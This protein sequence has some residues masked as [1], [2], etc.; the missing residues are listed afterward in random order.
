METR[1]LISIQILCKR[2]SIPVSFVN[3]LHDYNLIELTVENNDFFIHIE[4]IKDVEKMM[5]LYY[6]LGIN[7][8][9]MDVIYNLLEQVNILKQKT[10]TLRNRLRLYEGF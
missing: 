4:Q 7:F 1:D 9:G 3:T 10:V 5:R 6:D 2:Y 8:E